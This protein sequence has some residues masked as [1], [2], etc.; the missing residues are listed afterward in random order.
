MD[1][2]DALKLLRS[3]KKI[4][5]NGWSGKGQ[6]LEIQE[7]VFKG[8][9]LIQTFDTGNQAGQGRFYLKPTLPFIVVYMSSGDCVPWTASQK[10][11]LKDDWE[12]LE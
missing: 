10:D 12:V 3:G 11:L 1:F 4:T 9:T 7:A 2:S 8:A 5:R 6:W